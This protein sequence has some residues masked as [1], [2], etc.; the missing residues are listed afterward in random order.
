V[1]GNATAA[2]EPTVVVEY[3]QLNVINQG[4]GDG[5]FYFTQTSDTA[6][7]W[8]PYV[9]LP[10]GGATSASQLGSAIFT[11]ASGVSSQWLTFFRGAGNSINY[12]DYSVYNNGYSVSAAW[13]NYY[14]TVPGSVPTDSGPVPLSYNGGSTSPIFNDMFLF[15]KGVGNG[16]VNY[17][18]LNE[19]DNQWFGP[20]Q[21][22]YGSSSSTVS[23]GIAPGAVVYNNSILVFQ[24]G[25][26]NKIYFT[27]G[28]F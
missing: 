25:S 3:G 1:P 28:N 10:P 4:Q 5:R 14:L 9:E 16:Q 26:D 18:I 13:S 23:T 12:T 2:A 24:R 19:A 8:T 27:Q 11:S 22:P 6:G 21:I 17:S 15:F 7:Q 20:F